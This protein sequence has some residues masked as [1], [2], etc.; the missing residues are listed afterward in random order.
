M[1]LTGYGNSKQVVLTGTRSGLVSLWAIQNPS[2]PVKQF[3]MPANAGA[4]LCLATDGID[5]ILAGTNN[6]MVI[7]WS[8]RRVLQPYL[9]FCTMMQCACSQ[10]NSG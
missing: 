2:A 8:M 5:T 1:C 9:S 4:I 3:A 7:M 10:V 6:N